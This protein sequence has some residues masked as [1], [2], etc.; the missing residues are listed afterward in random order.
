MRK[1]LLHSVKVVVPM[2]TLIM[3]L[4]QMNLS[5]AT[6]SMG[7]INMT[8]YSPEAT[9][10]NNTTWGVVQQ[11]F[12]DV[13]RGDWFYESVLKAQK[14]GYVKGIGNGN[15]EP[16]TKISHTEYLAVLTRIVDTNVET[17]DIG[18]NWYDKYIRSA[19]NR[20]ILDDSSKIDMLAPAK[21]Q[22][23]II[24]TCKALGLTPSTSAT[25][26]F[27]DLK[28][29]DETAKYLQTAYDNYLTDGIG[30]DNDGKVKFGLDQESSRA[31]LATMALRIQDYRNNKD[32]F[33]QERKIERAKAE[34][35]YKE[36]H[37]QEVQ[38]IVVN[39]FTINKA[40]DKYVAQCM[41]PD[42]NGKVYTNL[43]L[44]LTAAVGNQ[45]ALAKVQRIIASKYGDAT[46]KMLI[47]ICNRKIDRDHCIEESIPI[48]GTRY[49]FVTSY[50]DDTSC[51]I[52]IMDSSK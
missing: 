17:Q 43:E 11:G 41:I 46:A 19:K 52:C 12:N 40:V 36:K 27:S 44:E 4:G 3:L 37:A 49:W 21:R 13:K 26:I 25:I 51:Q 34:A 6:G 33:I 29:N 14:A 32:S 39:G 5:L 16:Q 35:E 9:S 50:S 20:K 22:D 15:Y 47:D 28:V 42:E 48:E 2:M 24:Y 18:M 8:K 45:E 31:E 1:K 7:T 10:T 23:M 38:N 30:Y